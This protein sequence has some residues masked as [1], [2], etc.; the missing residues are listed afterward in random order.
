[1][2]DTEVKWSEKSS[3]YR[4]YCS[5]KC[6]HNDPVTKEKTKQTC[7]N[8]FGANTNLATQDTKEKIK[9]TCLQKYGT[10]RAASSNIVKEKIKQTF[11]QKYGGN[12]AKLPE[13]KDKADHTNYTRY[14]RKRQS[15]CHLSEETIEL[16]NNQDLMIK[17]FKDDQLPV[18]EI[19]ER[20]GVNHSQLCVHFK[21]NLGIDISRHSVSS[22]ER[23]IREFV[24]RLGVRAEYSVRNIIPPKELDIF[25]PDQN[26]AIEVDGLAWHSELRGKHSAYHRDK[27]DRCVA[28]GVRLINVTDYEWGQKRRIVESRIKAK[29]GLLTDKIAA[30]K[31]VIKEVTP[32]ESTDFLNASH[33][34]GT[35]VSKIRLGLYHNGALVALM[36]FGK[37][38]FTKKAEWEL[39]RYSTA[40][41]LT[42]VGGAG[43]LLTYFTKQ[44]APKSIISYSD[45]RWNSGE[46]YASLGFEHQSDSGPN[47]WYTFRY[48]TFESRMRYQ[49]H[50]LHAKLDSYDPMLTEWENM[51]NNGYD[52]YWDC[53]NSVWMW[54]AS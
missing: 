40:L 41:D 34:Q 35:S 29:L 39:L 11:L 45:K 44:Y 16:K 47:Y 20:L 21:N 49:K 30:R 3:E 54:T 22:T 10:E 9:K 48:R 52:R 8:R 31:C 51:A 26:L 13:I 17:W 46:L 50:K 19:A 4:R 36:T 1:M 18:T 24:G 27:H 2:C 38:R 28:A 42:V 32:T 7:I 25:F 15:Q 43:R 33:I 6:A 53:G 37:P 12:P 5:S 23:Q 14:G